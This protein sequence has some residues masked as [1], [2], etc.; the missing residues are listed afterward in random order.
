MDVHNRALMRL[1]SLRLCEIALDGER[2]LLVLETLDIN[3]QE[4]CGDN[5]LAKAG[6][7]N[8]VCARG[9]DRGLGFGS[10]FEAGSRANLNHGGAS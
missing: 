5:R 7:T 4:A 2:H 10:F 6:F 9:P 1:V 8:I 3:G